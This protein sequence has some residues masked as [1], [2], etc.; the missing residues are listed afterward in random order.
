VV[1]SG[2][3]KSFRPEGTGETECLVKTLL[4]ENSTDMG[5]LAV[6]EEGIIVARRQFS[7]AGDLAG[8]IQEVVATFG[9]PHEVVVGTGPGSYTGL[10]VAS[11]IALGIETALGCAAYGC[12]SVLGY[13]QECYHVVGDARLGTVF[14]ASVK[15]RHL[16][17]GPELLAA[18]EFRALRSGLGE[19]PPLF[20]NGPVRGFQDLQIIRP[21]AEYFIRCR[22]AFTTT[23]EPL[24]LKEAHITL[25]APSRHGF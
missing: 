1:I 18:E 10:R 17:R 5:S 19:A 2:N 15:K 9:L 12:P 3:L 13:P 11:A 21:E 25:S 16:T 14:F 6:A 24:Y 20:A 4:V 22:D 8:T 7:K 23:L